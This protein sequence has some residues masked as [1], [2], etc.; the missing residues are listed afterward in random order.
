MLDYN[1]LTYEDSSALAA[2]STLFPER[3]P[4]DTMVKQLHAVADYC[5]R[6]YQPSPYDADLV[7]LFLFRQRDQA[8]EGKNTMGL[9]YVD[10]SGN[11]VIGMSIEAIQNEPFELCCYIFLHELAHLTD[12]EHNDAFTGRLNGF[13]MLYFNRDTRMDSRAKRLKAARKVIF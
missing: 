4:S 13:M 10:G 2:R 3:T 11:A 8:G 7:G 1:R 6:F 5:A 12:T 9:C